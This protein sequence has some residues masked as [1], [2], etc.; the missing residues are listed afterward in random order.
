MKQ[1]EAKVEFKQAQFPKKDIKPEQWLS[2]LVDECLN[3]LQSKGVNTTD[4]VGTGIEIH[5]SDTR[6]R[7]RVTNR[8]GGSHA[9]GLCYGISSS[10]GN[11]RV[12]EVD[13]ETDNLWDTIDTVAHEVTHAVLEEGVGH[14]G[15]F[16]E[17]V[18]SVFKL[19]GKPTATEPTE[20]MK[21]LF[22]DFLVAN[23]G[24]PHVAFRP[25]HNKQTTRM[26]KCWCTEFDCPAGTEK[27][28]LE[29]KGMIFRISSAVL[30]PR[31]DGTVMFYRDII[32]PACQAPAAYD[33]ETIPESLYS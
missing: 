33:K 14:K 9:V 19:G 3:I 20:E 32:C 15:M 24:Y 16:P 27:S 4:N 18:K 30:A 23:G 10:T 7:K 5:I 8:N 22:Y 13:R 21:E 25:R 26:V 2:L 11:K 17:I 6:G 31:I 28:M 29:G 12:I 1:L